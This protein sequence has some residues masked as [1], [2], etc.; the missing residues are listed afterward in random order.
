M[1]CWSAFVRFGMAGGIL[2]IAATREGAADPVGD[3]RP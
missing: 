1:S 3:P 2:P